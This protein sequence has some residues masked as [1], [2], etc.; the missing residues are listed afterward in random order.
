MGK[1]SYHI[2]SLGRNL[3]VVLYLG[4]CTCY[5]LRHV[6][7]IVVVDEVPR[8]ITCFIVSP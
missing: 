7:L 2:A 8:I 1:L 4:V 6:K 5:I 3:S